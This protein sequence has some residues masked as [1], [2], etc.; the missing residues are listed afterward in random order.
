MEYTIERI[1]LKTV[2]VPEISMKDVPA[3][4]EAL[5]TKARP[6][7]KGKASRKARTTAPVVEIADERASVVVRSSEALADVAR[8]FIDNSV[9][10]SFSTIFA[11]G[12]TY[13]QM[14]FDCSVE[15]AK[16]LI[17]ELNAKDKATK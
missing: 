7:A 2:R 1:P 3:Y 10:V 14:F 17:E 9:G 5:K 16:E 13:Y 8:H 6:K 4:C 11:Y 12:G 15:R